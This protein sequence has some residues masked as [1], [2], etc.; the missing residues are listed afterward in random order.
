MQTDTS[1]QWIRS[2]YSGWS[3][4]C[5][6]VARR[7]HC[8]IVRDSKQPTG[9]VLIASPVQWSAFVEAVSGGEFD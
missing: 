4:L 8:M 3:N 9:P 2:T 5:V 6:E 1:H 7:G